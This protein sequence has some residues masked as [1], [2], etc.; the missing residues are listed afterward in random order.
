MREQSRRARR[1]DAGGAEAGDRRQQRYRDGDE[2]PSEPLEA[3]RLPSLL[4]GD[5]RQG[6]V[7]VD[8]DRV[9][10]RAQHRQ[11]G[12]RVRVGVGGGEVDVVLGGEGLHRLDLARAVDEG[13]V[14]AAGEVAVGVDLVAGADPALHAEH[15]GQRLDHAVAGGADDEGG[16]PGVLVAV[17]LVE[18]L[19]VDARQD[20]RHHLRAHPLDR[21]GGDPRDQRRGRPAAPRRC[22]R[23]WC[24]AAGSAG[25][26]PPSWRAGGG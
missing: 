12:E 14:E 1:G 26:R 8:D 6:R 7:G 16:A 9:A 22:A 15:L 11:V 13:T 5:L 10:D 23:R 17:D 21:L 18:H 25:A 3:H 19:R 24:R 4:L 2:A 20:R